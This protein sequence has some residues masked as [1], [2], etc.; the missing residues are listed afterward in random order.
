MSK[1]NVLVLRSD[2]SGVGFYRSIQPHINLEKIYP[3]EFHVDLYTP[4]EVPWDNDNFLKN[5]QILHYHRTMCDYNQMEMLMK[6][7]R[8]LGLKLI[9][10]IDDYFSVP[11]THP[12]YSIVQKDKLHEKILGN[13]KTA[14]WV[15]TTTPIYADEIRKYN[16]NVFILPNTINPEMKQ[17]Q[18]KKIE[19]ERVA[20]GWL[21][22]SSHLAD[23]EILRGMFQR[24][25]VDTVMNKTQI[26][27]CGYDLRGTHTDINPQTGE[28]KTRPITPQE[29]SWYQFEK[30]FTD[31]YRIIKDKKYLD[32]LMK[33]EQN[34]NF[35]NEENMEYRRI[36]TKLLKK[37]ATNYNLF[38]ISVAPLSPNI[39]NYVKSQLKV[40]ESGFH[41]KMLITQDY[42]PYQIDMIHG[43]N[44]MLV[45]ERKNH[46]DWFKFVKQ[47]IESKAMR[48][49]LGEALYETVKDKY[50][51]DT[52]SKNRRSFYLSLL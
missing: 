35:P 16:K 2:N 3:E 20:V 41:H 40:I 47:G 9:M 33:F 37:Y 50:H 28:K 22:G 52:D 45:Q 7:L 6:K 1:I 26:V 23:L 44:G 49:D 48:E 30:I 36:W 19:R 38:D 24:L 4:N 42:G 27:L 18:P 39:F 5:Y 46:K 15:T 17:F 25:R 34:G 29:T 14:D 43:K 12:M 10:D 31:E 51:I 21:G 8:G 32:Y 11:K 13:I